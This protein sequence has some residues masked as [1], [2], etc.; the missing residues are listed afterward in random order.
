MSTPR[1]FFANF[2]AVFRARSLIQPGKAPSSSNP[3][4][5]AHSVALVHPTSPS[6]PRSIT[7]N[8]KPNTTTTALSTLHSPRAHSTSPPSHSSLTPS[9]GTRDMISQASARRGSDSSSEGFRDVLGAEK[10]YIGGRTASGEERYFKLGVIKRHRSLSID[11][12]SL[13]D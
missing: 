1:P 11:R 8:T 12:L 4:Q 7:T 9:D 3:S 6:Q 5:P 10:W 2:L 13:T